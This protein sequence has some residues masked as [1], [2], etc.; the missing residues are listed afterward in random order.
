MPYPV[1]CP[2]L[3]MEV[4]VCCVLVVMP[5]PIANFGSRSSDFVRQF[6]AKGMGNSP[7]K[8][9]RRESRDSFPDSWLFR[10]RQGLTAKDFQESHH[11]SKSV[12]RT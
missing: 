10:D 3:L 5:Y 4:I 1:T 12:V 11:C 6:A 7:F 8:V 2:K 9:C